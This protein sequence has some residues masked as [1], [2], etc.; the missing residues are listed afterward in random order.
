MKILK[1]GQDARNALK[2]GIDLVAEYTNPTLG[3]SG[4]AVVLGR[5][6]LPPRIV[7]DAVSIAMNIE[8]DNENEHEG[9]MLMREAAMN[10]SKKI[11]DSTATTLCLSQAICSAVF[12]EIEDDGSLVKGDR[13]DTIQ[14]KKELDAILTDVCDRLR[15]KSKTLSKEDI[16]KVAL[17]A[18]SF[19]WI[20]KMATDVFQSV[21]ENGYVA[22]EE[23][24]KTGFEVLNG[25]DINAGFH[26]EYYINT[27]DGECIIKNPKIFVTNQPV[28]AVSHILELIKAIDK[29]SGLLLIAPDFSKDVLSRLVTTKLK[30][31]LNIIALKL[32]TFD[33]D[34]VL[35]DIAMA[36]GAKFADKNLF[37]TYEEYEKSVSVAML[38][39]AEKSVITSGKTKLIGLKGDVS[40]RIAELKDKVSKTESFFDKDALEKRVAALSGGTAII[41]L[42]GNT[43]FEKGYFKLKMENAVGSV[44]NA[45]RDGIVRGGGVALKEVSEEMP[46]NILSGALKAPYETIQKNNGKPFEVPADV[47]DA[48]ANVIGALSSAVSVAGSLLL[49]EG[50]ISFKHERPNKDEN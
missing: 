41:T 11:K 22:I 49:T 2:R 25:M 17:S 34:D 26:S 6:D 33:K 27:N 38:G 4:R 16:Y 1:K 20:A 10:S 13:K 47:F 29:D 44:Q 40:I 21:G 48:T 7:D 8:T 9:V 18:G 24:L 43:D 23:G 28:Y 31:D 39:T 32:P 50:V 37:T 15:T 46:S 30:T 36:T 45:L 42:G 19:E 12:K 14:L 3:P 35:V 5:V